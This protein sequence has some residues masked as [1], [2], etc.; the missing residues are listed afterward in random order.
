M[1]TV[2]YEEFKRIEDHRIPLFIGS[3]F[4]EAPRVKNP[5]NF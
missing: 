3:Q 5:D 1:E 2:D 4:G